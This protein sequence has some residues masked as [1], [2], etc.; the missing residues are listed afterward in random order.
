VNFNTAVFGLS[1]RTCSASS[2]A[3][4]AAGALAALVKG[5]GIKAAYCNEDFLVVHTDLSGGYGNSLSKVPNPPATVDSTGTACVTRAVNGGGYRIHKIPLTTTA[6]NVSTWRNN[7]NRKAFPLGPGQGTVAGQYIRNPALGVTYGLPT[8]GPVG[9]TIGGQE[10]YPTFDN[11]G[12]VSGEGCALDSCNQQVGVKGGQPILRGDPFGPQ[13]LY[14][15]RNY[16]GGPT[17]HPPQIGWALDGY[18]I[19]GRYLAATNLGFATP[20]DD[21]GGHMH[22]SYDYHYHT[23]VINAVIG[24]GALPGAPTGAVYPATTVGPYKCF[25]GDISLIP[26]FWLSIDPT[27]ISY[28]TVAPDK[29]LQPCCKKDDNPGSIAT[30]YL[31]SAGIRLSTSTCDSTT[32]PC[33][34]TVLPAVLPPT[35]APTLAPY[36]PSYAPSR[37]PTLRPTLR[38]VTTSP[39]EAP[40]LAPSKVGQT[41]APSTA[42]PSRLPSYTPTAEPSTVAPTDTPAPTATLAPTETRFYAMAT[43]TPAPT[44]QDPGMSGGD[45]GPSSF[46]LAYFSDASCQSPINVRPFEALYPAPGDGHNALG[47]TRP[48]SVCAVDPRT[49]NA[50][51]S[52]LRTAKY[53]QTA[54]R[55][56]KTPRDIQAELAAL[57]GPGLV[58]GSF[59][60]AQCG[61]GNP[62][63]PSDGYPIE[64]TWSRNASCVFNPWSRTYFRSTCSWMGKLGAPVRAAV[65]TYADPA[66]RVPVAGPPGRGAQIASTF[67]ALTSCVPT[68]DL[69]TGYPMV[70][71]YE[72]GYCN[73][74]PPPPPARPAR[75]PAT[76]A[77]LAPTVVRSAAP[78]TVAPTL[79][80]TTVGVMSDGS[81]LCAVM[82]AN[83][84]FGTAWNNY[85]CP[86]GLCA[87]ACPMYTGV[88]RP[89]WCSWPTVACDPTTFRVVAISTQT[90]GL[91]STAFSLYGPLPSQ[92]GA[93]DALTALNL[94][95][96]SSLFGPLPDTLGALS[97]LQTLNL[98]GCS[99]LSVAG[100]AGGPM[101]SMSAALPSFVT[102]LTALQYLDVSSAGGVSGSLPPSIGSLT[103]LVHLG[104]KDVSKLTGPLP[105][106]L[107]ALTKLTYLSVGSMSLTGPVPAGLF[108]LKGLATLAINA[109]RMTG[110]I[111]STISA[112][113]NLKTLSL[114]A[115]LSGAVPATLTALTK[116]QQLGIRGATGLEG[117]IPSAV[118]AN[119]ALTSLALTDLGGIIG[120]VPAAISKLTNLQSLIY[121]TGATLSSAVFS[122]TRLTT[123]AIS[124][125]KFT[126]PIPAPALAAMTNLEELVLDNL[127]PAAGGLVTVPT[128]IGNTSALT[129]L[130]MTRCSLLGGIPPSL[131]TLSALESLDLTGNALNGTL[132]QALGGMNHLTSL[133]LTSNNFTGPF[134]SVLSSLNRLVN[135]QLS[136]NFFTGTV[137]T[138]AV[139]WAN[140]AMQ[141]SLGVE[142]NCQ[143]SPS[144]VVDVGTQTRC[145][146]TQRKPTAAPSLGPRDNRA[147]VLVQADGA[148][149][150]EMAEDNDRYFSGCFNWNG[151]SYAVATPKGCPTYKDKLPEWCSWA[152]VTCDTVTYRVTGLNAARPRCAIDADGNSMACVPTASCALAG[153]IPS[154][155]GALDQLT[156][157]S[158]RFQN[159]LTGGLPSQML[160]LTTLQNLDL[161]FA[162]SL[163]PAG[164]PMMLG[165][166]TTLR[167]LNLAYMGV[168]STV[169]RAL[170]RLIYLRALHLEGNPGLFGTLPPTLANCGQLRMLSLA[171]DTGLRTPFSALAGITALQ[172]LNVAGAGVSGGIP[173][174][175]AALRN[176]EFLNLAGT[177][178][179][180]PIPA[181][182]PE[183]GSLKYVS[184]KNVASL[185]GPLPSGIPAEA[186]SSVLYMNM[187]SVVN[188]TGQI[189]GILGRLTGAQYVSMRGCTGLRG[190]ATGMASLGAAVY[191]DLSMTGMSGPLPSALATLNNVM[192]LDVSQSGINGSLPDGMDALGNALMHLDLSFTAVTG[193]IPAAV[194]VMSALTFLSLS[195]STLTGKL[196][197]LTNLTTLEVL[198]MS[199][200]NG[201]LPSTVSA[202]RMLTSLDV[203]MAMGM[204]GPLPT[205]LAALPAIA[206]LDLHGSG[207][208]GA[209]PPSLGASGALT[210]LD[211]S[212]NFFTGIVP[213]AMG[214]LYYASTIDLGLNW[215]T[216]PV[217]AG[218]V[219]LVQAGVTV[220]LLDN[221]FTA[222]A[223]TTI[224]AQGHCVPT[225][226]ALQSLTSDGAA[227]TAFSAAAPALI[228]GFGWMDA[229]TLAAVVKRGIPGVA[230]WCTWTGV[231]CDRRTQRV[232]DLSLQAILSATG[233]VG[234]PLVGRI[235]PALGRLDALT[236][237]S[238]RGQ[239]GLVGPLS[240]S[241]GQLSNLQ[242]L[243]LS[244]TSGLTGPIPAALGAL[245]QLTMLS[246]A[247][248]TLSGPLPSTIANLG[249]LQVL[250]LYAAQIPQPVPPFLGQMS[251]LT[252]LSLS[253]SYMTGTVPAF[254]SKL[255]QL[256]HLGLGGTYLTGP[257]PSW[258]GSLTG[259]T[260]LDAEYSRLGGRLPTQ[261]GL[262]TNLQQLY[263]GQTNGL[264]LGRFSGPIPSELGLLTAL[265]VLD[266]SG[267][268]LSGTVPASLSNLKAVQLVAPQQYPSSQQFV[269]AEDYAV[270][271]NCS[272]GG[273]QLANNLLTGS[274]PPEVQRVGLGGSAADNGAPSPFVFLDDNCF[275]T[276]WLYTGNCVPP[277]LGVAGTK[278]D[279]TPG[280][281]TTVFGN[282]VR[283]NAG[284]GGPGTSAALNMPAYLGVADLGQGQVVLVSS[285]NATTG[286][287]V[288][289]SVNPTTGAAV[290][291]PL[292]QELFNGALSPTGVFTVNGP[293][294]YAVTTAG[295]AR[296]LVK[297][298]DAFF[299]A[300]NGTTGYSGDGGPATDAQFGATILGLVADASNNLY[301][302]DS[303]NNCVR[304]IRLTTGIVTTFAG[305]GPRMTMMSDVLMSGAT[306]D[307]DGGPA[308]AAGIFY[309]ATLAVDNANGWLYVAEYLGHKVRRVSFKTGVITTV[310]GMGVGTYTG[311]L[312]PASSASFIAPAGLALDVRGNLYISDNMAN[313]IRVWQP[314][315]N[316]VVTVAG[317]LIGAPGY[318]GDGGP[319]TAGWLFEPAGLLLDQKA[320]YLYVADSRN[321]RVRRIDLST[322]VQFPT[323][324]P[325]PGP[326]SGQPS[327]QPSSQPASR[328]S[329]RPSTQPSTQP[330]SRPTFN[331]QDYA[332]SPLY[333]DYLKALNLTAQAMPNAVRFN[334][335]RYKGTSV[336][337]M[338]GG[339]PEWRLFTNKGL[340]LPFPYYVSNL[341]VAY[342]AYDTDAQKI[343]SPRNITSCNDPASVARITAALLPSGPD[344]VD[345][346]CHGHV[347]RV[348]SCAGNQP[349]VCVDCPATL[350]CSTDPR[351]CVIGA[352]QP[353]GNAL[354]PYVAN[355]PGKFM[356]DVCQPCV[357]Q[358]ASMYAVMAFGYAQYILY[359]ELLASLTVTPSRFGLS[360]AVYVNRKGKVWCAALPAGLVALTS[361]STI[362]QGGAV[363]LAT[364]TD[365]NPTSILV[366]VAI[367]GLAPATRY[368]VYCYT[369]DFAGNAMDL[370]AVVKTKKV[371][372][373]A[374]CRGANF[375]SIISPVRQVKDDSGVMPTLHQFALNA[376]PT[377]VLHVNL[378]LVTYNMQRGCPYNTSKETTRVR[379]KAYA[380]PNYFTFQP[381]L[382]QQLTASFAVQGDPGCYVLS[383]VPDPTSG[384]S[385][386]STRINIQS[387]LVAPPAPTLASATFTND[388]LRLNVNFSA[389][390]D[391]GST[392]ITT[393]SSSFA[394]SYLLGF[395]GAATAVCSWI[396]PATVQARFGSTAT[397]NA[398]VGDRLKLKGRVVMAA[399]PSGVRCTAYASNSS[400]AIAAPANPVVPT[401]SIN[402]PTNVGACDNIVID[403]TGSYGNGGRA[404]TAVT[405]TVTGSDA[406][407][408]AAILA[409]LTATYSSDTAKLVT[410]KNALFVPGTYTFSL[411]L[412]NFLGVSSI[413]SQTI[414]VATST[415]LPSASIQSTGVVSLNRWQPLSLFCQAKVPTCAGAAPVVVPLTFTWAL[416]KGPL[417][418]GGVTSVS[419]DPRM[420]RLAP[421][422]LAASTT[423]TLQVTVA[424]ADDASVF[425]T[426]TVAVQVGTSGLQAAIVGGASRKASSTDTIL[427][428]ASA[429]YDVDYPALGAANLVFTWSCVQTS[430]TYGAGCGNAAA[431]IVANNTAT[432]SCPPGTLNSGASY[433]F[434][435]VV[436]KVGVPT[437][438]SAAVTIKVVEGSIPVT[439][440][441]AVAARYNVESTV[442][443]T[444]IVGLVQPGGASWASPSLNRSVLSAV[445]LTPLSKALPCAAAAAPCIATYQLAIAPYAL[446]AGKTYVFQLGATYS[447]VN[448]SAVDAYS[449][450]TVVMNSPPVGGSIVATPFRG[451]AFNTSFFLQASRWTDDLVDLPLTYVISYYLLDPTVAI[452]VKNAD[453][454]NYARTT[455]GQGIQALGYNVT[456][457]VVV[458][459]AYNCTAT[460]KGAAN[461]APVT[462][463]A[464]LATAVAASLTA[465]AAAGDAAAVSQVIGAATSAL[466]AVD[467]TGANVT[468]CTPLNRQP[469]SATALTCGP[470][471]D[472]FLGTPGDAN[473]ACSLPKALLPINAYCNTSQQCVTGLCDGKFANTTCVPVPKAC[474]NGCGNN[475]TCT[476]MDMNM[477]PLSFCASTDP[478]CTAKCACDSGQFGADCSLSATS[479]ALSRMIREDLCVGLR[480]T[481]AGQDT[482]GDAMTARFSAVAAIF[483]DVTQMNAEALGNCTEALLHT[484]HDA[485]DIAG[486]PTIAPLCVTALSNVVAA[487]AL[488]PAALAGAVTDALAVLQQGIQA[489]MA[490]GQAPMAIVTDNARS[491]TALVDPVNV[492]NMSFAAPQTDVEMFNN[493]SYSLITEVVPSEALMAAGA[494]GVAVMQ[495][496]S[497][498]LGVNTTAIPVALEVT[499][500]ANPAAGTEGNA[501]TQ[502]RRLIATATNL[503][504]TQITAKL[505]NPVPVIYNGNVSVCETSANGAL[506]AVDSHCQAS[507]TAMQTICTCSYARNPGTLQF[508]AVRSFAPTGQPTLTPTPAPT[509]SPTNFSYAPSSAPTFEPTTLQPTSYPT[510]NQAAPTPVIVVA[511][512]LDGVGYTLASSAAFKTAF[513][514]SMATALNFPPANIVVTGVA[515]VLGSRRNRRQMLVKS[516]IMTT[517]ITAPPG[518]SAATVANKANIAV[519]SGALTNAL[520]A[521]GYPAVSA[522]VLPSLIKQTLSPTR[523]P[524]ASP[525]PANPRTTIIIAAVVGGFAVVLMAAFAIAGRMWSKADTKL[526]GPWKK[527]Q[528]QSNK[529]YVGN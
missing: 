145:T 396:T 407:S 360:V 511:Q 458:S 304:K 275:G 467:C 158:F 233:P 371:A 126:S 433:A 299:V 498:P 215:L 98:Q 174:A 153:T 263:L 125:A 159:S 221:C 529:V 279:L 347:F 144:S 484:I 223:S 290:P 278:P 249:Y 149:L 363:A 333:K 45:T 85:R 475:G 466:N 452:V 180:G 10:M 287:Y 71:N 403:P 392:R 432:L 340:Q 20:L 248:S 130:A 36:G 131:Y 395:T 414:S 377:S 461:V 437:T 185:S 102:T 182:L 224:G 33:P 43:L 446:T 250:D 137:P 305:Q 301:V 425:T 29:T 90:P 353:K 81:T 465:A 15:K 242:T 497:N 51:K 436:S 190:E 79:S 355:S 295:I 251:S 501:N 408:V 83:P 26:N 260:Y 488:L 171:G 322:V 312:G 247:F 451:V 44:A 69:T 507:F 315:T 379:P 168:V 189:S 205:V 148:A 254:L 364:S 345:E 382:T 146:R 421:Y 103:A 256:Q 136:S 257:L 277:R 524:S 165:D 89:V 314:S 17:G 274:V 179:S 106:S 164:L 170:G 244:G 50:S 166:L 442:I 203:S 183:L 40:T 67:P 469:C 84:S 132:S 527:K 116:L 428:D 2:D 48:S 357:S 253:R 94:Y 80:A 55:V 62:V 420:F 320:G 439:A 292:P 308:S 326:P 74:P 486:R 282:G 310:A 127:S 241:L 443:L 73:L 230:R 191:V 288:L 426:D 352:P 60:N 118:F 56:Y 508:A 155:I 236:S 234:G 284:D 489:N 271:G 220:N 209:L 385:S 82:A 59:A 18:S 97:N 160:K 107:S 399:C 319:A 400:V 351:R 177:S 471:L 380:L 19:Y 438:A 285:L 404:W 47:S 133:A 1:C 87:P 192:Y 114:T 409:K 243:D 49:R 193:P 52:S 34:G 99:G 86:N 338:S 500:Y 449:Q 162:S 122:L 225:T 434:T 226:A 76:A 323:V 376:M 477:Q 112:L 24:A 373:T 255:T 65:T 197:P 316:V 463:R 246:L 401:V 100:M 200:M 178:L 490:V 520:K 63:A 344:S 28:T 457:V 198:G 391:L 96:Q 157:L 138:D 525:T 273:L 441:A 302:A 416:Y 453:V 270:H 350:A 119:T 514:T 509:A 64:V 419:K 188:V 503:T 491:H 337:L 317:S 219:T 496:T 245:S 359:P 6:I 237:L 368:E 332:S 398:G 372:S 289:R 298:G 429:S 163:F 331:V 105:P 397:A 11:T 510:L 462:S 375:T 91:Q 374:C 526:C 262:L 9:L 327:T 156:S 378:S 522:S 186:L 281:I 143:L 172:H 311:D 261:L 3:R 265:Q 370:P 57:V 440:I 140:A 300:G 173:S 207:M 362:K 27:I 293:S 307:G 450:V 318:K 386:A 151:N 212:A 335:F 134:P 389:P 330:S 283:G 384:Y 366:T 210:Y 124:G 343:I 445:G 472:G 523:Y 402:A 324:S 269:C 252:Y 115:A 474:P 181:E 349:L 336:G 365:A 66:C 88:G 456:L 70:G 61:S 176:L 427:V 135:I 464:A 480:G 455:L 228:P 152:G 238:L 147:K 38:G 393:A 72:A 346:V 22:D 406:T 487:G 478:F 92:L 367:P 161:R 431:A 405:W 240:G 512:Q 424:Q 291:A 286:Q 505:V 411:K 493:A 321:H 194:G 204:A 201:P 423:Y 499:A 481:L 504:L 417:L 113:V 280:K 109:P 341:T 415:A 381:T 387:N 104:V 229:T 208:S 117:T 306:S 58:M 195:S 394:C 309:P 95:G 202:L 447:L 328:P 354:A 264:L 303:M 21:C 272:Y 430:P 37:S 517:V 470:C 108:A 31:Q 4:C 492:A 175:I 14:S 435:V 121:K 521:N 276:G 139:P 42:K 476:F 101:E 235:P 169:P 348:R 482:T 35:P 217:P 483:K 356:L 513:A 339:C 214:N 258:V 267:N 239:S 53:W 232:V 358:R 120:T 54:F 518:V 502:R 313:V 329:G 110:S 150:C 129:L 325:S 199:R 388:G 206:R 142:D 13:C 294:L 154:T 528:P 5:P 218:L 213:T 259:L 187:D 8:Y 495:F 222:T 211:L 506:Y 460:A 519:S 77:T 16:T 141:G 111:P 196:P 515:P 32:T 78:S 369:E 485:P 410:I 479:M 468:V 46:T 12:A 334:A 444:G 231:T 41:L 93:L 454:T 75:P 227:L 459:D 422:A 516:V 418:Q 448:P 128:L 361:A 25:K 297:T 296:F 383:V 494:V 184:L 473:S 68:R 23:Q 266:V 413:V 390:T 167:S 123:L 342:S 39:S 30:A 216:G 268:L 7:V 412:T